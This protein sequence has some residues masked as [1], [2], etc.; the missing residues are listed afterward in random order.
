MTK[1]VFNI[2]KSQNRSFFSDRKSVCLFPFKFCLKIDMQRVG[3]LQKI[4]NFISSI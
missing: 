3:K 2:R 4:E 1:K